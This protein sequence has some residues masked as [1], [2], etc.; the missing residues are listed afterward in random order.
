MNISLP[1]AGEVMGAASCLTVV[2]DSWAREITKPATSAA[3]AYARYRTRIEVLP[4]PVRSPSIPQNV[5]FI[6]NCSCLALSIVRGRPKFGLG[7]AGINRFV[8]IGVLAKLPTPGITGPSPIGQAVDA[9][10]CWMALVI[11]SLYFRGTNA[12]VPQ[13]TGEP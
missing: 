10:L 8:P 3:T 7:F 4:Q 2:F 13:N 6:E 12:G 5:N 1:D 11:E 9:E